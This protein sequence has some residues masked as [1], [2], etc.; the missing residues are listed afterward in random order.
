ME[1]KPMVFL[2]GTCNESRWREALIPMLSVDY[3][4]PVV[5]DW[6]A[7]AQAKELEMRE[8]CD[9]CLCVITPRMQGIY[10]I[11]KVVDDS[12]KR[13]EKTVFCVIPYDVCTE[14]EWEADIYPFYATAWEED[15]SMVNSSRTIL[16]FTQS[17]K[18][19]LHAVAR[20]VERNGGKV[21]DNLFDLAVYFNGFTG[22]DAHSSVRSMYLSPDVQKRLL[23]HGAGTIDILLGILF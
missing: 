7:E 2:G 3:F 20:L 10:S 16:K 22:I 15:R 13:P 11:A 5:D 17:Q 21:F 23:N 14:E 4:N 12:N 18:K 6:N 9:F 1:K 19:S 8:A